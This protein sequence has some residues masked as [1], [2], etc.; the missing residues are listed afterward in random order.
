MYPRGEGG[1]PIHFG[2][3]CAA[4]GLKPCPYLRMNQ[5]KIDTLFKAQTRNVT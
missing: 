2:E 3:L 4:K 1:T 5:T